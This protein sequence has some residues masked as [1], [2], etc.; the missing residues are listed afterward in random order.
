MEAGW[1]VV[2]E[3]SDATSMAAAP[4]PEALSEAEQAQAEQPQA[5]QPQSIR[6]QQDSAAM[7]AQTGKLFGHRSLPAV[8]SCPV[9]EC[10]IATQA[11]LRHTRVAGICINLEQPQL[12][13]GRC[14][15]V[16]QEA[17]DS[18]FCRIDLVA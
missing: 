1:L 6:P 16:L 5:E 12:T 4:A 10:T 14:T 15:N 3:K 9:N 11:C 13:P 18:M 7:A 2:P 8:L 17:P